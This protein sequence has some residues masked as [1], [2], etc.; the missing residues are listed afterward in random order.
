MVEPLVEAAQLP[1]EVGA[2]QDVRGA[3]GDLVTDEQ[4][5][6]QVAGRRQSGDP[7]HDA[8]VAHVHRPRV[9]EAG[10]DGVRH[11]ELEAQLVRRPDVVV[12]QERNPVATR[13][14]D[15][16]VARVGPALGV[17]EVQDAQAL[18]VDL[19]E[20]G[21]RLVARPVV[22]D[23][24]LDVDAL[25]VHRAGDRPRDRGPAIPRRDD[26]RDLWADGK[27]FARRRR[28]APRPRVELARIHR[29]P[30]SQK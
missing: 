29:E 6:R 1:D 10:L 14:L 8:R 26:D 2:D 12:V 13:L 16:D 3:R 21:D 30:L 19:C 20:P 7:C 27:R 17:R 9:H 28:R 4:A 24:H 11:L 25:L 18:V 15:P 23:D 22:D 5:L